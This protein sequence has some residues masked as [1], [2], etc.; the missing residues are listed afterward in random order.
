M[1]RAGLPRGFFPMAIVCSVLP[2]ADVVAFALGIPY[3][4]VLGHRG[5]SH[6][7]AFAALLGLAGGGL[8]FWLSSS[9][10][11]LLSV[12][13][14]LAVISASHGVLDALTDGGL[15]VAFFAPF[16]NTRIFLPWRPIPVSPIGASAF[17][18]GWGARVL[19]AELLFLWLPGILLLGAV[20][21]AQA[22]LRFRGRRT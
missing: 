20:R 16:D 10:W 9:D 22:R 2:D 14:L 8:L 1:A 11:S 19:A 21:T 15:G 12:A 5:L 18:S 3:D 4:H 13:G 7:L 6:S 17:L